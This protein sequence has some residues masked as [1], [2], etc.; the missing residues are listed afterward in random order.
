MWSHEVSIRALKREGSGGV[1]LTAVA[2]DRVLLLSIPSSAIREKMVK[3]SFT[4]ETEKELLQN[5]SNITCPLSSD[6]RV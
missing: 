4:I 1:E 3:R 2:D 5:R 6:K